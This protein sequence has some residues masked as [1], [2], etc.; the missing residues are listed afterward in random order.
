MKACTDCWWYTS[1]R[2]TLAEF[3]GLLIMHESSGNYNW[4]IFTAIAHAQQLYIGSNNSPYSPDGFSENGAFNNWAAYSQVAGET[5]IDPYVR[6]G[7]DIREY[8]GYGRDPARVM[9][10]AAK[11]GT[12]M[13]YP[14]NLNPDKYNALSQYSSKQKTLVADLKDTGLKPYT[15][16]EGGNQGIYYFT[17]VNDGAAIWYAMSWKKYW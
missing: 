5:F 15:Y 7:V 14:T 2:F 6:G 10:E 9:T 4:M 12:A 8:A 16:Y 3:F 11:A 1:G 17:D 13:L